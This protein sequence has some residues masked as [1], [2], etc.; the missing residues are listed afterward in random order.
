MA[1]A[2]L[3]ILLARPPAVSISQN[4]QN[5][6]GGSNVGH[7]IAEL[8]KAGQS[9]AGDE[10][11]GL[12]PRTAIRHMRQVEPKHFPVCARRLQQVFRPLRGEDA[13]GMPGEP[14]PGLTPQAGPVRSVRAAHPIGIPA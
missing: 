9:V 7:R 14:D 4:T 8:R 11:V 6:L 13:V 5:L 12:R 3:L 2:K 10:I 1:P